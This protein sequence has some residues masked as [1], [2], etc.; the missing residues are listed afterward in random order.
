MPELALELEPE[1]EL[2]LDEEEDS[3]EPRLTAF[4][5]SAGL[6]LGA[7]LSDT[8][9]ASWANRDGASRGGD[10]PCPWAIKR[11]CADW[12]TKALSGLLA[13]ARAGTM[14]LDSSTIFSVLPFDLARL[15]HL[16]RVSDL[17]TWSPL[18]S[19]RSASCL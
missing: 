7:C 11:R 8:S 12:C 2:V 15:Y 13:L 4:F 10:P 16:S 17:P 19:C 18:A 6:A 14:R 5:V 1:L 9:S 3:D